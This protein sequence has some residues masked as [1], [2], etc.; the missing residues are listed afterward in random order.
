[1]QRVP[2]GTAFALC[3]VFLAMFPVLATFTQNQTDVELS[4]LW[5]PLL[6]SAVAALAVFGLLLLFTRKPARASVL[7]SLIIGMFFYYGVFF[8][9]RSSR[10]LLLWL[11]FFVVVAAALVRFVRDFVPVV[12]ALTVMGAVL[13]VPRAVDVAL[14]QAHHPS[15][16][17]ADSRLWPAALT[18]PPRPSTPLPDIYVIIPDD[19]ERAD[20]LTQYLHYD[21]SGFLQELRNRGFVVSDQARSPYSDSHLN[22]AALV[23][24]D[25]LSGFRAVLGEHSQDIRPVVR[26]IEDSRAARTA[27]AL[28]YQYVHIDTDEETFAGGN[29]DVSTFA[30]DDSFA[31]LWLS[32]SILSKVGGSIGLNQQAKNARFR[33]SIRSGFAQ[34][35]SLRSD[36]RPKFVVFHT[37]LPHDPYIYG[38]HG[39]AVTFPGSDEDLSSET[40]RAYYVHQLQYVSQ[41]LLNSVDQIRAHAK[42]PP[43][44]LI[45]SDE[46]MELD[47]EVFGE[48]AARNIRVKGLS[49][50]YLPGKG[51][52]GVPNPPNGVNVL[53]FV[54]N[55]YFGT[56]YDMLP[57][58]SYAEGDFPYATEEVAVE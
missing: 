10:S 26:A 33:R 41:L 46:G 8:G 9:G 32:K 27:K 44:I 35:G 7:A 14:Y 57:T 39:E 49:A 24:M 17:P 21:D 29:P 23:N 56:N 12:L 47:S 6:V 51:P 53:R 18:P 37:L 34:L 3:P 28:G 38:P 22:I 15:L 43:V 16:S 13:A 36:A 42:T 2:R 40:G 52:V 50:L 55:Q 30:V 20:I 54:F 5:M 45:Q 1:M 31:N 48:A 11:L 25:Y 19:Y 4:L 58:A